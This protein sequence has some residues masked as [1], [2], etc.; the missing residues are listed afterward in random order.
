MNGIKLLVIAKKFNDIFYAISTAEW[1]RSSF[2]TLLIVS[3][4]LTV[5]DYPMTDMFNDIHYLQQE[6]GI[7]GLLKINIEIKKLISKIDFNVVVL[8]NISIVAN[9]LVLCSEK[10]KSAILVED[11]LMNYYHFK[12]PNSF[13]KKV[14][15]N[16]FGIRQNTVLSKIAKTYLL[17]PSEAKYSFGVL[18]QLKIDTELFKNTILQMPD[19]Q[20]KKIF[21]GQPLYHSYTGNNLSV[22]EYNTI[23]NKAISQFNIDFYVP[24]TM[25]DSR[26][27]INCP[28]LDIGKYKITFEILASIFNLEFYS[29]SS[30]VLYSTKIINS[31]GKSVMIKIPK[32]KSPSSDNIIYKYVDKIV[33]L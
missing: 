14:L 3:D 4:K 9:K 2:K 16:L 17:Q 29:I 15:M 23:I 7:A 18:E 32:I 28:K 27:N 19:I 11:G 33:Q 26:E 8:S 31:K 20:G 1:K 5:R 22:S 6:K 12:E 25:A 21:I 13:K 24:H 30:T 10:C